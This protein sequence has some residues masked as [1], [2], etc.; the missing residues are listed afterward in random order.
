[1]TLLGTQSTGHDNGHPVGWGRGEEP[2]DSAGTVPAG[3]G[4]KEGPGESP[5]AQ[6]TRIAAGRSDDL[7]TEGQG[8]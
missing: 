6:W 2:T 8:R 5:I 3:S 1:M 4:A 7:G